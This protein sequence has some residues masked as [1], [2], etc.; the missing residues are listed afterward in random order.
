MKEH[1]IEKRNRMNRELLE[2]SLSR[3]SLFEIG[4]MEEMI[5]RL[6]VEKQ[7]DARKKEMIS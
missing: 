1:P 2:V 5:I 4:K 7:L 3:K 6:E